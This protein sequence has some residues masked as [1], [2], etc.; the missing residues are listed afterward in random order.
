MKSGGLTV[1]AVLTLD[2]NG[3]YSL[4]VVNYLQQGHWSAIHNNLILSPSDGMEEAERYDLKNGVLMIKG[5]N[6]LLTL[7]RK[8]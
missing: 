7:R 4:N 3:E 2:R 1:A 8:R 6:S 5:P